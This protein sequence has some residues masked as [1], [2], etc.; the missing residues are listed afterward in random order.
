M[1]DTGAIGG[2]TTDQKNNVPLGGVELEIEDEAQGSTTSAEDGSYEFAD[3][4]PG[5]YDIEAS[6]DGF[7]SEGLGPIIVVADVTTTIDI[8]MQAPAEDHDDEV[9]ARIA[10]ETR[11][12]S[13]AGGAEE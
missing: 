13:E 4:A 6:K 8:G 10:E 3:L 9:K 2:K 7:E 12:H 1:S 5:E 11:A